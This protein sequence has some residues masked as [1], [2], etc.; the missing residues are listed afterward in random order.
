MRKRKLVYD[1]GIND[2]DYF[3]QT[4]VDGK[5]VSC[6]FYRTWYDMLVRC[7]SEKLRSKYPTYADCS[8]CYEWLTFSNF[9]KWMEGQDFEGKALDKDI[10][11]P[12][13]KVY[14]PDTCVFVTGAVNNLLIDS[15]SSR[16]R[17]KQGVELHA[18]GK[19]RAYMSVYGKRKHLK[20]CDTEQEAHSVYVAA[21]AAHIREVADTQEPKV[22]AGL[23]RHAA[24]LEN[25]LK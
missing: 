19:F 1:I 18:C 9:K 17:Y 4:I 22:R 12:R 6:T 11:A 16:G 20:L 7:Y 25:T 8:V 5:K 23:Y 21:K 24:E 13:N 10:L 15:G 14:S 3:T 2:A